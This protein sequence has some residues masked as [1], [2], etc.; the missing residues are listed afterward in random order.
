M[1]LK[2]AFRKAALAAFAAAGDVKRSVSFRSITTGAYNATTGTVTETYTDYAVSM[3]IVRVQAKEVG[4]GIIKT[5]DRWALIPQYSLTPVPK[6]N[7]LIIES[8]NEWRIVLIKDDGAD[9]L[10]KFL[11]RKA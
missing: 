3:I 6:I 2:E 10:W 7:D 1:S 4:Q 5:E 11:V 8:S 9:A